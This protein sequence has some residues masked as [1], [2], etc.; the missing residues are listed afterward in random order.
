MLNIIITS[1]KEPKATIKAIKSFLSQDIRE[2]YKIVVADPFSEI[3]EI[4]KKEFPKEFGKKIQ[5]F[6]D[7]GEGK[8]YALNRILEQIYSKDTNEIIILTDGDV[9]VCR[10]SVNDILE[11]FKDEKIGCVTGKPTSIDSR[12][13]M[14]GFWSHLLLDGIDNTRK[15]LSS[16]KRFF[17]CSGYLFAIRNGVL[18]G[19]PLEASEDSIIPYLFWQ[20]GYKIKYVPRA[21]IY[22]KN[23]GNWNDWKLQKIRNIKGHEN[24]NSLVKNMPRTKSFWNEVK[25]GTLFALKYP[26]NIKELFFTS[27]LFAARFYIYLLSFYEL[28]LRKKSYKDGWRIKKTK[29][30]SLLD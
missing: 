1:Y 2:K 15:L 5:F 13:K 21:E 27:V 25:Y 3:E 4:L 30:T 7:P 23:P 18:Q 9:Y 12:E 29:S 24:L 26:K 22:V 6:L 17:E 28:K 14:L 19:F 16:R 20:K 8:S 11:A 10:N